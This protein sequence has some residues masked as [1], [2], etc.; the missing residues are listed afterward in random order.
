MTRISTFLTL[1]L[2]HVTYNGPSPAHKGTG[3]YV[4]LSEAIHLRQHGPKGETLTPRRHQ[5]GVIA[6]FPKTVSG[7]QHTLP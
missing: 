5:P 7:R 1:S 6:G 2:L 3:W 4:S